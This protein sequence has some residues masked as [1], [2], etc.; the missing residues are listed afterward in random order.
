MVYFSKW[1]INLCWLLNAKPILE[2]HMWNY[3][4]HTWGKESS[5]LSQEFNTYL[6]RMFTRMYTQEQTHTHIHTRI[7]IYITYLPNQIFKECS[8]KEHTNHQVNLLHLWRIPI[9]VTWHHFRILNIIRVLLWRFKKS[10]DLCATKHFWHFFRKS[11]YFIP[12]C[13]K[14]INISYVKRVKWRNLGKGVT[15]SPT[16]R[17][18][19]YWQ[20]SLRV[21]LD[22]GDQ[23]YFLLYIYLA[24]LVNCTVFVHW[25]HKQPSKI[26]TI[27][28][29]T[30]WRAF[31]LNLS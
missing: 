4:S 9:F 13:L 2:K 15:P 5:Y 16:L 11:G 7:H 14:L 6:L 27:L 10:S 17:C 30:Q 3:F 20:G 21:T 22:Y 1:H 8:N 31:Y 26:S 25:A 12:P 23:L 29:L 18:I 19:N 24:L 28:H